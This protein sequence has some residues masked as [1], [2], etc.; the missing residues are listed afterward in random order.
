MQYDY[1]IVGAGTAGCVLANRLSA[2]G[3]TV[4]LVEAGPDTPTSRIPA[5]IQD[6]YPRSYY[7]NAYM[8]PGL[9]ADQGGDGSGEQ[10]R[11]TQA[12]VMGGGSSLMGMIALRGIP[13]DYDGWASHGAKGW[14]WKEVLPYF[15]MVEHDRDFGGPL[16][17]NEGRV[18]IR[19]HLPEDWPPFSRAIAEAAQQ[20]GLPYVRDFN[21]EFEDGYGSLPLSA[22]L[23]SRISSSTAY[24]DAATRARPNLTIACNT[25]VQRLEFDGNRCVGVTAVC[26]DAEQVYRSSHTILST[27]AI[28]SPALLMRSGIGPEDQLKRLGIRVLD[29]L[30]GVGANLQNHPIVYLG[31]H[32]KREARQAPWLR[33]GFNAALRFSSGLHGGGSDLQMLILNKS[34]WHGLGASV[35]GL[36]VCL[37]QPFS[38]GTVQ[39]VSSDPPVL[40]AVSFRM[41]T[42]RADRER[43]IEGLRRA[44]EL[45]LYEEVRALRNE[46]FAAGY[47]RVVRRLNEPGASNVAVTKALARLLDGPSIVRKSML[48]WGIA[49]GDVREKR[50]SDEGWIASTVRSHT[51]GTYHPV[52]TCALG[53]ADDDNAV[54]DARTRVIGIEG[55]RVVDASIMPRIPRGNTNLPVMMVAERAAA[56]ILE[57]DC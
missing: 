23:S 35:A 56:L 25:T 2:D 7:N 30:P 21:G 6:I 12:R 54:V 15:R 24:L 52:G 53:T 13:D 55:L 20:M 27:G 28:H 16:H 51:F 42:E 57:D 38:R 3:A 14:S 26:A 39:L 37:M 50:L 17:G 36:G 46:T 47:S 11:Y 1:V 45:M 41:L 10:T 5:D 49:S 19:R 29:D 8:W 40:P 33:P 43:M 31:A 22:T 34:S 18:G 32:I 4:V 44:A 9:T 48:R